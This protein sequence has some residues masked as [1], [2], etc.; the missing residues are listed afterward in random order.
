MGS[1]YAY[2]LERIAKSLE[3]IDHSLKLIV[4]PRKLDSLSA[5][6]T[7]ERMVEL[8]ETHDSHDVTIESVDDI[9]GQSTMYRAI[10]NRCGVESSWFPNVGLAKSNL[11][12]YACEVKR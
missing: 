5:Y 1:N 10:C 4:T 9:S 12:R 8:I 6:S 2:P 7:A 3:S 11:N